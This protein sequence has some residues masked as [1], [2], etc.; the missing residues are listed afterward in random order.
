MK[1]P[2]WITAIPGAASA[3]GLAVASGA[4][5]QP[6]PMPPSPSQTPV[7]PLFRDS[8]PPPAVPPPD[9]PPRRALTLHDREDAL[10]AAL[11]AGL[12]EGTID[13]AV[14][15]QARMDLDSL[16]FT[17][18]QLRHRNHGELTDAETFRLDGRLRDLAG[19]I[20]APPREH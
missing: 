13:K 1:K 5:G 18:D 3:L 10:D 16:R 19:V 14:G 2:I 17:E 4:Q 12:H 20:N 7:A 6:T 9:I 8:S 15:A 11:D